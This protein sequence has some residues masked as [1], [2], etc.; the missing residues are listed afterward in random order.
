[1]NFFD[2]K[3]CGNIEDDSA[4]LNNNENIENLETQS[5]SKKRLEFTNKTSDD[6]FFDTDKCD[7]IT[8]EVI[9]FDSI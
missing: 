1:M 6:P 2:L 7:K 8:M 3:Q 9:N 5:Y 4:L